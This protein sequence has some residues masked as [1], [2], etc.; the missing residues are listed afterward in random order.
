MGLIL[1]AIISFICILDFGTTGTLSLLLGLPIYV[2][3]GKKKESIENLLRE[4][5]NQMFS[6]FKSVSL[7]GDLIKKTAED[8]IMIN[9]LNIQNVLMMSMKMIWIY[10]QLI[11]YIKRMNI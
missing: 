10:L 8:F 2:F 7:E 3:T 9:S 11:N 1:E 4:N 6:K 5:A